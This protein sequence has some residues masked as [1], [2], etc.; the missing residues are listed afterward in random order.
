M[1]LFVDRKPATAPSLAV[2]GGNAE[3]GHAYASPVLQF[4]GAGGGADFIA[5]LVEANKVKAKIL[6][7]GS[8]AGRRGSANNNSGMA[9]PSPPTMAESDSAKRRTSKRRSF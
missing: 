6:D 5:S 9:A 4:G 8:G 3:R 7:R 2:L 1:R